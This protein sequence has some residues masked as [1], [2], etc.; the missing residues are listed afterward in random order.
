LSQRIELPPEKAT[1]ANLLEAIRDVTLA[2]GT[3]DFQYERK[4]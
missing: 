1:R 4:P 3:L 2:E